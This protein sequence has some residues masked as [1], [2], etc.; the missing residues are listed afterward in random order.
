MKRTL[1]PLT[2]EL[3]AEYT[4]QR[5][6][7]F[8]QSDQRNA[9]L[10]GPLGFLRVYVRNARRTLPPMRALVQ[11]LDIG[12]VEVDPPIQQQGLFTR[13]LEHLESAIDRPIFI[14]NVLN[15]HL[16]SF[17]TRRAS[18]GWRDISRKDELPCFL[19]TRRV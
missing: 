13:F 11:V 6:L 3:I 1:D 8:I 18:L 10:S 4:A 5:V 2:K 12:T 15:P 9:H 7:D 16:V 14:E 17:L 19:Y